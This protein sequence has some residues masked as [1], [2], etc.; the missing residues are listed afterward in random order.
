MNA[1]SGEA[2]ADSNLV[3][4][5]NTQQCVLEQASNIIV[6]LKKMK[7]DRNKA[8]NVLTKNVKR[9]ITRPAVRVVRQQMEVEQTPATSIWQTLDGNEG[10]TLTEKPAKLS[11]VK[12]LHELWDEWT[13]GV[14][15][16]R[17]AKD[18][19]PHEIGAQRS[20]Y[21]RYRTIW[22]VVSV[23][24]QQGYHFKHYC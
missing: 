14:G 15:G 9:F 20:N 18:F 23:M 12:L 16:R 10:E 11:K 13:K 22:K 21:S 4:H 7:T 17:A 6:E 24:I 8:L 1:V 2:I 5:I 3:Q 19:L